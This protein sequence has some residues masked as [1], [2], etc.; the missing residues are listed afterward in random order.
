M[1]E[2][3]VAAQPVQGGPFPE[4][5]VE[6]EAGTGDQVAQGS[7]EVGPAA[8]CPME[9]V[10]VVGALPCQVASCEGE[11]VEVAGEPVLMI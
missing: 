1:A 9:V 11:E 2:G 6:V 4:A 8:S 10:E 5:V 3:K 7:S